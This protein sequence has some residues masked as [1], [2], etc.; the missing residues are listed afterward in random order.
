MRR[1]QMKWEVLRGGIQVA[2]EPGIKPSADALLLAGFMNHITTGRLLDMGTGCGIVALAVRDAGFRGWITALDVNPLACG[3][4]EE[5]VFCNELRDFEVVEADLRTY[6]P[7]KKYDIVCCNPP[8]F[9]PDSGYLSRDAGRRVARHEQ[10]CTIEAVAA[11]ARRCLK[12]GGRLMLCYAPER[13]ADAFCAL[14]AHRLEPKRL[15]LVRNREKE[16]AWLALL[17]A[18]L[19]GG[20]GLVVMPEQVLYSQTT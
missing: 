1:K 14:R 6:S 19:D 13:L 11:A 7:H 12:Q 17:E 18:R 3:L 2:T 20:V 8:Y 5:A 4:V 9:A 15:Q 10:H 16:R